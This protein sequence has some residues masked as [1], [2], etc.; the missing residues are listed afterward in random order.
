MLADGIIRPALCFP[1]CLRHQTVKLK[2]I[3]PDGIPNQLMYGDCPQITWTYSGRGERPDARFGWRRRQSPAV[4]IAQIQFDG[5]V[6]FG[7]DLFWR[8]SAEVVQPGRSGR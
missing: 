6:E 5:F 3:L 7:L 8:E 1:A 2:K 4:E